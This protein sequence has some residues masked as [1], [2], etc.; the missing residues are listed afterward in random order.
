MRPGGDGIMVGLSIFEQSPSARSSGRTVKRWRLRG[1]KAVAHADEAAN[2]GEVYT[3]A[4]RALSP[5]HRRTVMAL[6]NAPI[7]D[8]EPAQPERPPRAAPDGRDFPCLRS[9]IISTP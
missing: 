9:W 7:R 5:R 3:T 2:H 8:R 1:A 6:G 4:R